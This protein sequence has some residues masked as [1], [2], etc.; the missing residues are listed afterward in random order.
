MTMT[1][2][3][4]SLPTADLPT[5]M[6]ILRWRAFHQPHRLAYTFLSDGEME[7]S[8]LT[9][10]ELDRQARAIGGMLQ[11]LGIAGERVLLLFPP[12]IDY[13]VAFFA[14]IYAD[15]VAVPVY[16]PSSREHSLRR[17]QIIAT[18]AQASVILTMN[19][20]L[21]RMQ[22]MLEYAP[23]LGD[24]HWIAID[25]RLENE[26][27]RW[28]EPELTGDTLAFLQ[29]TSGS[30][31]KPKGV[32]VSHRNL[33]YNHQMLQRSGNI[34]GD[35]LFMSWLPLFHDLGLIGNILLALYLGAPCILM[36][37]IAFLQKPLRWLKAISRYGADIS[38]GPNFAYD[39]C[40][41]KIA[42]E[43]RELL[44]LSH[45]KA[46]FVGSEP[47]RSQTL[48]QFADY[49]ECCGFRQEAFFPCYGLAEATLFVTGAP[50]VLE[51]LPV[52]LNLQPQALVH[53]QVRT[54][55]DGEVG[56]IL[57][58]CGQTWLDQ[59]VAIVDPQTLTL[60]PADRIGEIWIAGP[61][62]SGGYWQR[63]Q[64]TADVFQAFLA[65]THSGPFL[66]TGDLGFMRDTELFVTGRLKDLIII[67]GRNYYP[68]DIELSVEQSHPGLRPGCGAAFSLEVAEQE[69]L[70]VVQE[71]Q[72]HVQNCAEIFRAVRQAVTEQHEVAVYAIVLIKPGSIRKTSSG[73]IQRNACR[74]AFLTGELE[75]VE[76][77]ISTVSPIA[78]GKIH[79][80]PLLEVEPE[81]RL[82]I[83]ES[84][85]RNV[86]GLALGVD[87]DSLDPQIR[88]RSLGFDSLM[89]VEI[90]NRLETELG[91][92]IAFVDFLEEVAISELAS[93]LL[94]RLLE[95]PARSVPYS[96]LEAQEK[97][98][99]YPLSFAQE[100]LWFLNQLEPASAFYN[101]PIALHIA[102]N[103]HLAL[104]ERSCNE[105]VNRHE[106]L[107]TAFLTEAGEPV[108]VVCPFSPIKP[109][110]IN[111]EGL[112]AGERAG[113]AQWQAL[114]EAQ[115]PF[116]LTSGKLVRMVILRLAPQEHILLLMI[117][118]I[119]ID[120]WSVG[121]LVHELS[122]LY[123]TFRAGQ[124]AQLPQLPL[125]YRDYVLW[126][127][128][129]L[130]EKALQVDFIYWKQQLKG[131]VP[132]ELPTDYPY[133]TVQDYRGSAVHF[134]LS[135]ELKQG[136]IALSRQEGVTLFMTLLAAFQT[137]LAYYT[138]QRDIAVGTP[139]A[140]RTRSELEN[141]LGYF[142]NILVLR[143]KL[144][145]VRDF[146]SLLRN[147]RETC[148]RAYSHQKA[149][150]RGL[151]EELRPVRELSR[152][153]LFQVLFD[154]Q[155]DPVEMLR[156]PDWVVQPFRIDNTTAKFDIGLGLVHCKQGLTGVVEYRTD[157]FQA[158]TIARMVERFQLLLEKIVANPA[159]SLTQVSLLNEAERLQVLEA[160]NDTRVDFPADLC[161]HELFE[162][163]AEQAS[164]GV[165]LIFGHEHITYAELNRR[166]DALAGYLQR[167]GVG[168]ESLV[169][170][171]LERSVEMIVG[172]LGVLKAG[173]VFVPLDPSYPRDMLQFM[174]KDAQITLLLTKQSQVSECATD[175]VKTVDL[176]TDWPVITQVGKA[177]PGVR[178]TDANAAYVIYTS[179]STGQPKGTVITHRNIV[180][181]TFARRS[182]YREA[183]GC[184]LL[185]SSLAFDISIA[186][187]FW[188]LTEGGV[189]VLPEPGIEQDTAQIA[190]LIVEHN[191]S[192]F[193]S[194]PSLY[195][196][197]LREP[198]SQQLTSL[199][200]VILGGEPCSPGLIQQHY[201][202]LPEARCF[203]EYG[204]TEATVWTTVAHCP[205]DRPD[206]HIGR[207]VANAQIYLLDQYLQPVPVGH[208]G[209]VYIGGDGLARSYLRRPDLTA[210]RFLPHPFSH[211]H[212]CRLY[213]TGDLACYLPDGS[214]KFLGRSDNQI[215]LRGFR[216]ELGEIEMTLNSHPA[217]QESIVLAQEG[218][219]GERQLVAYIVANREYG[220]PPDISHEW[221]HEHVLEWQTFSEQAFHD[222]S[223]QDHTTFNITGWNSS[224]TNEPIP[225]DEMREQVDQ[226]VARVLALR[227]QRV[228][229]I[230]CGLGLILFRVA[231]H[232][233]SYQATDFS[234]AALD[235]VHRQL[236]IL[237]LPHV[238]LSQRM[239]HDFDG[240]EP[241]SVDMVILNSV[242][243]YFPSLD[244]LREV[245]EGAVRVVKPG[246]AIFLGDIRNFTL[247]EAYHTSV[248]L[249]KAP[250]QLSQAD[251]SRR[252]QKH[253]AEQE[254][255]LVDPQFFSALAHLLEPVS[256]VQIQLKRG[257][258]FN[259]LTC[260]RYDVLMQ[261]RTGEENAHQDH[262]HFLPNC[263]TVDWS[264][265]ITLPE[266]H[267][268]L[269]STA[270]NSF[271]LTRIPNARLYKERKTLAWLKSGAEAQTLGEWRKVLSHVSE[272]GIDPEEFWHLG[273]TL[274]YTTIVSWS[275][276]DP[277]EYY[278]VVFQPGAGVWIPW[279][280]AK[281]LPAKQKPLA[282]PPRT[283]SN[284]PLQG[285]AARAIVPQLLHFLQKKLPRHMLPSAFVVL[286]S[287]PLTP[288]NKIDRQALPLP[289]AFQ[290][291]MNASAMFVA[292]RTFLE[293][294]LAAIWRDLLG[295]K[296]VSIYHNFFALGGH[297]LLATQ[298]ISHVRAKLE[299]ELPLRSVWETPTIAELAEQIATQPGQAISRQTP[300]VTTIPRD[301]HPAL[302]FDQQRLWFMD[303]LEPGNTAY[304]MH[305]AIRIRGQFKKEIL[306]KS[307]QEIVQRHEILRTTFV[308]HQGQ[309]VQVIAKTMP[310]PFSIKDFSRLPEESREK[311][312]LWL[313]GEEARRSFDLVRGP[314]IHT[315]LLQ[316]DEEDHLLVIVMHHIV[317]DAWSLTIFMHELGAL[318]AAFLKGEPSP[319]SAL[320]VQYADYSH[321]QR[322]WLQ[323]DVLQILLS[324]W[325]QQLKGARML[326]LPTDRPRSARQSFRGMHKTFHLAPALGTRLLEISQRNG[327]T[328][329]MALLAAFQT[330]LAYCSQQRDICVGTTVANRTRA[331][332]E[333]L[334]GFFANT[335]VLRTDLTGDL[336][337]QELLVRIREVALAAYAHQSLPFE[338]LVEALQVERDLSRSPL[339]QVLF[340]LQNTPI[341]TLDLPHLTLEHLLIEGGTVK[342][343]LTMNMLDTGQGL[344][345]VFGYNTDLFETDTIQ[346]MIEH[347]QLLLHTIVSQPDVRIGQLID[348]LTEADRLFQ[349]QRKEENEKMLIGRLREVKRKGIR[350]ST[351]REEHRS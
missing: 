328:L 109:L 32:M 174:L 136:L 310:V 180:R 22:R 231:P 205:A 115:F 60:C 235:Y 252:I 307:L 305:A 167:L 44:D 306:Q 63:L 301:V 11:D 3:I 46:A 129:L 191:V 333:E 98:L 117:H 334:I 216:I 79:L 36:P 265:D 290:D 308:V 224:Y 207:P 121:V 17:L 119:A 251:L 321:W 209:E 232:C 159:F 114:Q 163:R 47:V 351:L 8:S 221:D 188:T 215:K 99:M 245:I 350:Y 248:E 158:P 134:T 111:L 261:V 68:Q 228:L 236:S 118:H 292:P 56:Q 164:T 329:F 244:Y 175:L 113:Q 166:A 240:I 87:P 34:S 278:T 10:A 153:P 62:V 82:E 73:K 210:E 64:E 135:E 280:Q 227:P 195:T 199:H 214:L 302:S 178:V 249:F 5:L 96:Q 85:L 123:E 286:Q 103:L 330:L 100:Q 233:S 54:A 282:Q 90:K 171:C 223:A 283:Y 332:F 19:P 149:P 341:P 319:L 170:I 58:G 173:G 126:Q 176:E 27:E 271:Y 203:I 74:A 7:E 40:V 128:Q 264:R 124:P 219:S 318:Y 94:D 299:I 1:S 212:G 55:A 137:L 337:F 226:A 316:V 315:T 217:V 295:R 234:A 49:F 45:W 139:V 277:L 317:S 324:Y 97:R 263:E 269:I 57:V 208:P 69:R 213:R 131:L 239:A 247:L 246:G 172:L 143:T 287:L 80:S 257:S 241:A 256:Q 75:I 243:Q 31:S 346:R 274:G 309:P 71:V 110:F 276:D 161:L 33:L 343:D 183:P 296:Q 89:A 133:P 145:N 335:I 340:V 312:A 9:Y 197:L 83:L 253:L 106:A 30:T 303:Q 270:R 70:V 293:E 25:A 184:F 26:A 193:M 338:K 13:I 196:S 272:T 285:R 349:A 21:L 67:R 156:I 150:F 37:S 273:E 141:M 294:A 38:G 125:Q 16:P 61:G 108:Q 130:S 313:A 327:G 289:E 314:L 144:D 77:S 155:N 81:D 189:L 181:S 39:L 300:P 50:R 102:G 260:F 18:D 192:H 297:S 15:V 65:D 254:E 298:F 336:T 84:Y 344:L 168:P 347:F 222:V 345:G 230:G 304:N 322:Q 138:G 325:T 242:V 250:D 151:V 152:N 190:E 211:E 52:T 201:A 107:R 206:P 28:Q 281:A 35:S 53:N 66:R 288:N 48:R 326:D 194:V 225:F 95:T 12:G 291:N 104:L 237:H 72:R 2:H 165:S 218:L 229:E 185:T 204:L 182:Y 147:V 259:E 331:E 160:W 43:Q 268:R 91:V 202:L 187:I 320:P 262:G 14:C 78:S 42:P 127:R 29:Y 120:G 267:E 112:S 132:L 279:E 162:T 169:G 154:L 86:I 339:F 6:H 177:Q 146:R 200:T 198:R 266:I 23:E 348:L 101:V 88:M 59:Q 105:V 255:L 142:V 140:N 179:G 157:L 4:P 148:M 220:K 24:L 186:I 311:E 92:E 323:K 342:F 122:S 20:M 116:D 258:A 51:R 41:R 284:N 93:T 76:S 275:D 238:T